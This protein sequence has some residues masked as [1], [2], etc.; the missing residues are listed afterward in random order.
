[1]CENLGINNCR[2]SGDVTQIIDKPII[3][4]GIPEKIQYLKRQ[5]E[6]YLDD[7]LR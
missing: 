6:K 2:F 4:D 3:Y 1:M 7:A 5:S